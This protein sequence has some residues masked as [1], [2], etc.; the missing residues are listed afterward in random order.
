MNRVEKL[1][2]GA[3]IKLCLVASVIFGVPAG[4]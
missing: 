1:L 4:P 3:G 2:E